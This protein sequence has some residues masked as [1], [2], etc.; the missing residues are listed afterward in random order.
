MHVCVC[1]GRGKGERR[2]GKT[3]K[4]TGDRYSQRESSHVRQSQ[5]ETEDRYEV[6]ETGE[7]AGSGDGGVSSTARNS[8]TLLGGKLSLAMVLNS[9]AP[10]DRS[11]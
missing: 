8:T 2:E 6:V 9:K 3:E 1:V 10:P 5:C 4:G 7:N 11:G